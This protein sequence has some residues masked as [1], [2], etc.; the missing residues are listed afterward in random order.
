M[1]RDAG[2][3]ML[4]VDTSTR[5]DRTLWHSAVALAAAS[6]ALF[7]CSSKQESEPPPTV[8]VQVATAEEKPIQD[9][10]NADAVLYPREQAAIVPK[11]SAPVK[12][13]YVQRGSKVRAGQL[14]AELEDRD[15]AGA[16]TENQGGYQQAEANYATASQKAQQDLVLAKQQ[17]DAQQKIYDN[18]L[19][20]FKQGAVS[21]KDVTDAQIALT[22]ARDQYQV[23]QKQFDVQAAEGQLKAAK[24]KNTSAAAQLS[25]ARIVSPL[26][27]VVTD[28]PIYPGETAPSGAPILTVMD[29]SQV[30]ARAHIAQQ[31]AAELKAG[32]AAKILLPGQSEDFPGKVTLVSPAL[33]PS[34]TTVEVWVQAANP[35]GKLK[36]GSSVRVAI[37]SETVPKALVVPIAS[38]LTGP[39]GATSVFTL[40]ASNKPIRKAV[41]VGIRT[42]TDA[43][44]TDGLSQGERVV[45]V[46][47]FELDKEDEPVLAKTKILVEAPK[48][49]EAAGSEKE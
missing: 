44:I 34:S 4:L 10:V 7:G 26:N 28:R 27:G 13:F 20:L 32:D 2:R 9:V 40:D 30:I 6:L 21:Q 41:K 38:V 15:L 23:A 19:S 42:D 37:V 1:G 46:G 36:P 39:D 43:Q 48:A 16:V 14:L 8:T 18:R 11:I 22:Q 31:E 35:G 12:K 47:A 45:T 25:Y 5:V 33:D 49:S 24:G 3:K 29:L 17:L